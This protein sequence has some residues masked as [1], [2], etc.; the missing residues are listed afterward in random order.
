MSNYSYFEEVTVST[1]SFPAQPQVVVTKA[2]TPNNLML[3]CRSGTDVEYSFN[4]TDLHGKISSG[5]QFT[6][7]TRNVSKIFFSGTGEVE[8]HV[9]GV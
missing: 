7:L 8:V 3:V 1:G 6:F 5:D 9:W 2:R 4:G